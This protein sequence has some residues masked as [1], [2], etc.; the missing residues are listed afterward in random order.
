MY[1]KREITELFKKLS[2]TYPVIAIVGARQSGKTTFLKEQMKALKASYAL[3]DDPDARALFEEDI[4]KFE[5]QYVEGY[6]VAVLDEAQ[7]CKDAGIKI[8]YLAEKAAEKGQ[9]I[10]I[11]SSSEL[12]LGKEVWSY[13]VGRVSI[14]KLYPFSLPE[15]LDAKGQKE[16][17]D[18]ILERNIWEH[19]IYGGYPKAVIAADF[20]IKK[21]ILRDLYDTLIL[22]DVAQTFSI[23]DARALQ[24]FSRYLSVNVGSVISYET[25][26][27]GLNMAFQTVKKYFDAMEKSYIV[28]RCEPFC[29]NKAKEITK[30][31]KVYF[32]D[33]GLRNIIARTFPTEPDGRLF[34]SYVFSELMKLGFFPKYW[35]TKAKAEVDF[36][37]E[38][39]GEIIPIEVKMSSDAGKIE[40]GMHSFIEHYRPKRAFVVSYKGE[41]RTAT[42]NE[43]K[44]AF[45]D[46][47][48]LRNIHLF[49]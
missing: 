32:V 41:K 49:Q 24:E 14:I 42:I 2:G 11:T 17:T 9:K 39:N 28:A 18:K 37:I 5:K 22:K 23:D 21:I 46:A 26:S 30:Q 7:Y 25:I 10:W 13:L 44:I 6:D 3:F 35:R 16:L 27:K 12:I 1:V 43:C 36:I 20:E 19:I 4:K 38:L 45:I 40:R 29:T 48:E 31:P 8:K 33:T 15:F 47:L 34:E